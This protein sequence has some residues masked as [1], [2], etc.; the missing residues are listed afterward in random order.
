MEKSA[1]RRIGDREFE[2]TEVRDIGD[3]E[4][5]NP[6]RVI[7]GCGHVKTVVWTRA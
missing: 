1:H 2:G 6:D 7:Q 4:T 3:R 5:P